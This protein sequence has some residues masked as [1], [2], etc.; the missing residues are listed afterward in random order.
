VEKP[1]FEKEKEQAREQYG[2]PEQENKHLSPEEGIADLEN[3]KPAYKPR[4]NAKNF[5]PKSEE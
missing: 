4:F 3:K 1:E 5:K 2:N